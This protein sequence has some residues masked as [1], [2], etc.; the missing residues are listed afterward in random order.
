MLA[1]C[2]AC[3]NLFNKIYRPYCS[4]CEEKIN[5]YYETIRNFIE[6]NGKST[7]MDIHNGPS[8]VTGKQIGRAH[9]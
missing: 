8:I 1:N 7:I 9:V 6:E 5:K 3:N 4:S 2:K